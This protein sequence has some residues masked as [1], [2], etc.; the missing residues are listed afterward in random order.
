MTE[1][2]SESQGGGRRELSQDSGDLIPPL[3]PTHNVTDVGQVPSYFLAAVDV[4]LSVN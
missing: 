4:S 1:A 2:H 3:A